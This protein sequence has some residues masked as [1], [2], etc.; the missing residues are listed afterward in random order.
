MKDQ[1][2][3]RKQILDYDK[4]CAERSLAEDKSK[5]LHRL[6]ALTS[7]AN[8]QTFGQNGVP[9][10]HKD[11]PT[12]LALLHGCRIVL[13][14]GNPDKC[15]EIFEWLNKDG[16][17]FERSAATH[18]SK[19]EADNQAQEIKVHWLW[20]GLTGIKY[21]L[22]NALH[23]L[24]IVGNLIPKPKTFHYGANVGISSFNGKSWDRNPPNGEHG[25]VYCNF[26]PNKSILVLG[27]EETAPGLPGH[28]WWR[29][30]KANPLAASGGPKRE[31]LHKHGFEQFGKYN[32]MC[33][34]IEK[35]ST[36]QLD[37]VARLSPP[38]LSLL[39][40]SDTP[41][42]VMRQAQNLEKTKPLKAKT[43]E[44]TP[45]APLSHNASQNKKTSKG[46]KPSSLNPF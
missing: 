46:H 33:G 35:I 1:S 36:A 29:L 9:R 41:D 10:T 45:D 25:H 43:S 30:G 21:L 6:F 27:I 42:K 37:E 17:F 5:L 3:A 13:D 16:C 31:D 34:K 22:Q 28:E 26:N 12:S 23:K 4:E 44:I 14:C 40:C 39:M 7:L 19:R 24:P 2:Q 11:I 18:G 32:S 20:S 8:I 15:K 38:V